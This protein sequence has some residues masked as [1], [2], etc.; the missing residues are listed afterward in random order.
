MPSEVSPISTRLWQ[1]VSANS[2]TCL[3]RSSITGWRRRAL[4]GTITYFARSMRYSGGSDGSS[5][6]RSPSPTRL[7]E[8]EMR[9]VSRSITGPSNRSLIS[10]ATPTNSLAS[11]L[12]LGSRQGT[13]ANLA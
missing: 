6:V 8:C 4:P 12:S 11:W 9:V 7:L 2:L 1:K 13:R 3:M 5:A 10:K